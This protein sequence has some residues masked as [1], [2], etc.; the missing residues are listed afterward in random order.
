[1][2]LLLLDFMMLWLDGRSFL[3]LLLLLAVLA[4]FVVFV[5]GCG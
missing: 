4:I 5:V 2:L 1:M 3:L